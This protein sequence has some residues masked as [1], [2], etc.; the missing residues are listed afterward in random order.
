MDQFQNTTNEIVD[1]ISG[2]IPGDLLGVATEQPEEFSIVTYI[3]SI[4]WGTW[5]LIVTIIVLLGINVLTYFDYGTVT[6]K[7]MVAKMSQL[8]NYFSGMVG[9]KAI[10][11]GLYSSEGGEGDDEED[12]T[13]EPANSG[14]TT[15]DDTVTTTTSEA[16]LVKNATE[17]N[18][19]K[20]EKK[21]T[22]LKEDP[23]SLRNTKEVNKAI[24]Y[25]PTTEDDYTPSGDITNGSTLN[26]GGRKGKSS[27][28]CYV[29][30][31]D[32]A[33]HCAEVPDNVTC[34]SNSVFP[35]R[36]ICVNQNLR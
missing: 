32:D 19:N 5:S 17:S 29:G 25:N 1:T 22:A 9:V 2:S 24:E 13:P 6:P 36:D 16:D 27:T 11:N 10:D 21:Q 15:V 34:S 4:T 18:F 26:T 12:A 20:T 35:T 3:Q 23:N 30:V 31:D 8:L 14:V 33:R 28:W 7:L